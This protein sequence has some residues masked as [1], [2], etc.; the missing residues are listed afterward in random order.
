MKSNPNVAVVI[1]ALNPDDKIVR[2]L[3]EIIPGFAHVVIVDDGSSSGEDCFRKAKSMGAVVLRHPANRGKGAALKT[4]FAWIVE[5]LPGCRV[6]VTA[7]ADGQHKPCD[8]G[9]VADVAQDNPEVLTLGVRAFSGKVPFRSWFGNW[10]TRIFFFIATGL[11]LKDTQTGLRGIPVA[12]L[13]RI[14]MLDGERY[15]Y[16][17]NMLVDAKN[18]CIPPVEVP[19]ETVYLEGNASS[20]FNALSDSLRIYG[21]LLHFGLS[22]FMCF[23]VDNTVFTVFLYLSEM[24]TSW[25]RATCVLASLCVARGVSATLNYAYNRSRV[26]KAHDDITHSMPRYWLL[27]LV[28]GMCSYGLTAGLARVAD[29]NGIVITGIKIVCETFLFFLS[30]GI[31]R[32]WVFRK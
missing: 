9:R 27:V 12:L 22:G 18:H 7:D 24:F 31:Q 13:Q 23:L 8:I 2:L 3:E 30:Y 15:E 1:P 26:F 4:A 19:I 14:A 6:V 10:W 32:T 29:V 25:R 17:M 11:W 21:V 5:N 20:H 28:V 16:E